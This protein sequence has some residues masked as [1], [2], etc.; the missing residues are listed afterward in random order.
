MGMS[1]TLNKFKN[2]KTISFHL[3]NISKYFSKLVK[4]L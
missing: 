2:M 1:L 4:Q 3:W